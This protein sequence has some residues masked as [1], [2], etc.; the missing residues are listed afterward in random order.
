[1]VRAAAEYD[2]FEQAE[3]L[4]S[5]LVTVAV[6]RLMDLGVKLPIQRAG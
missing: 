1:M 4:R 6:A 5:T 2:L 3:N